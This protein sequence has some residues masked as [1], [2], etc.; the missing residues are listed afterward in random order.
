MSDSTIFFE[1]W[2]VNNRLASMGLEQRLLLDSG[3]A[4]FSAMASCT[5]NNPV[6]SPGYYAWSETTRS[7]RE[8]LIPLSWRRSNDYGLSL[9]VSDSRKLAISVS[10]GDEDTGKPDG[11]PRTKYAKG[12]RTV[13][14]VQNN[15]YM[16]YLLPEMALPPSSAVA[17]KGRATWIYLIRY[18]TDNQIFVSEL[19]RPIAITDD[20]LIDGWAERIILSAPRLGGD[21]LRLGKPDT[22]QT[23][24]I[25]VEIKKLA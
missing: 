9:V 6:G 19:S 1:P 16:D 12:P 17:I 21:G 13:I 18:D 8:R 22:P 25:N 10:S 11:E 24:V 20:G 3:L 4:G 2:D 23:P 14:A 15:K 7:L 5:E